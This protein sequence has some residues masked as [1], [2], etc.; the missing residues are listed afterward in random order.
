MK[1]K[2]IYLFSCCILVKGHQQ[3][4]IC[5]VQRKK[6]EVIPN[7]LFEI[8]NNLNAERKIENLRNNYNDPEDL[9]TFQ[10]YIQFL[11]D[12]EL[13]FLDDNLYDRFPS[14]DLNFE[15][16]N[17]ISNAILEINNNTLFEKL[18]N[19]ISILDNMRCESVELRFYDDS[20]EKN[21]E[22]IFSMFNETGIRSLRA[23]INFGNFNKDFFKNL[24]EKYKRIREMY[25]CT[26][27]SLDHLDSPY[28]PLIPIAHK[29]VSSNFCGYISGFHFSTDLKT[30]TESIHHNSCLHKKIAIDV[31]GNIKNCPSMSQNFGNIKETSI[32]KALQHHDFKKY[33]NLTK[34]KIEICKDCEFRYI[35]TDCRAFTERQ[36][37][38][39][40]ELDTSKP[41]KCGYDPYRGEWEEWS[42]N[43]LKQK[44]IEYYGFQKLVNV[45]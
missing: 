40:E 30:L 16:P 44:A 24:G 8:L 31:K 33:W 28:F 29:E 39:I 9:E 35:C 7:T 41:L 4:I 15:I 10:S 20:F 11:L 5:D 42:T 19:N 43:P 45:N 21:H 3:S 27:K 12:E 17:V 1:N 18:N 23:I 14:L 37:S 32:E 26:D 6:F 13:I 25:I 38:N 2:Y 22:K 34:D 36:N